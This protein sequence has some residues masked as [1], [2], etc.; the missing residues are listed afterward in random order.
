MVMAETNARMYALEV[1]CLS[2]L[3]EPAGSSGP[4]GVT[5]FVD[6]WEPLCG[7]ERVRFIFPGRGDELGANCPDCVQA[8]AIPRQRTGS[9]A[10]SKSAT[11]RPSTRTA[12]TTRARRVS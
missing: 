7:S 1:G 10:A 8:V 2:L 5:H 9:K 3:A 11:S 12:G 6:G 4:A